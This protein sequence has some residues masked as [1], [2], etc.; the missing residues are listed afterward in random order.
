MSVT[1]LDVRLR[2]AADDQR[3]VGRI[4][5]AGR[6]LVFQY[7]EAFLASGLSLSP[8]HLPPRPGV[9]AF[10]RTAGMELF[11]VFEDALPD[12]WGRRVIDR[13][14]QRTLKRTPTILERLAFVGERAMG[15]LTFHPPEE[16]EEMRSEELHLA[17]LAE[18]AWDFDAEK[19]EDA[20]PE[21]RRVAGTSGGARPK[22]LL[23]LP[24]SKIVKKI[25][26][27]DNDLP[28]GY[29]HWIVKFNSRSEAKDAGPLEFAYAEMAAAA[30]AE[31]PEHR[32]ITAGKSR[33]FATR[34]FDRPGPSSRIHMHSAAGLLHADYRTPGMEYKE[35]FR[36]ADLLTNDY[37]Q[38][39]ELFRRACLNVLACNRDDHLKNFAFTMNRDGSWKL[40]PLFDFNF[41]QGPNGWQTLSVAGEGEHPRRV[42]LMK[43]AA[44][45]GLRDRDASKI[46]DKVRAAI[47][48]FNKISKKLKL[49][50][51]THDQVTYFIK[52]LDS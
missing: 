16:S 13:H 26:P 19:I 52:Q 17:K 45:A 37:S 8:I 4:A 38:K 18:Q 44:E 24:A 23:G 40:A 41:H 28:D 46:L 39:R 35:L 27:G 20:L 29:R 5:V 3:K 47:G 15:A 42:H 33:F 48:S 2:F 31:V 49:S 22:A 12:S 9:H 7:D 50:K 30:G 14:F 36:L 51:R 32:L 10:N 11:G 34:R 43:L 21:L 6:D 1:L 25:L